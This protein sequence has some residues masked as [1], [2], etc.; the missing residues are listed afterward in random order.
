VPLTL[1]QRKSSTSAAGTGGSFQASWQSQPTQGNLLV[2]VANSDSALTMVSTGWTLAISSVNYVALYQFYK[3]AGA[4]ESSVVDITVNSGNFSCGVELEEYAGNAPSTPLDQTASFSPTTDGDATISTGTTPTTTQAD[5][6]ALVAFGMLY[7]TTSITAITNSFVEV[8][9]N[10]R[11]ISNPTNG[12]DTALTVAS[13]ALTAT[14]TQNAVGTLDTPNLRPSGI[15]GTYKAGSVFPT[16]A[17]TSGLNNTAL[18]T[19]HVVPLPAPAGG[20]LKDDIV[21]IFGGLG[22]TGNITTPAGWNDLL[23][24]TGTSTGTV[25]SGKAQVLWKRM[26]GGETGNV[27][28]TTASSAGGWTSYCI[29]GAHKAVDPVASSVVNGAATANIANPPA[30]NPATWGVEDTLWIAA[31]TV[32]GNLTATAAPTNYTDLIVNNWA[33]ASGAALATARRNNAVASEDPG[34]FTHGAGQHG[35]WVVAIRPAGIPQF[36]RR[37]PVR[38]LQAVNRSS[39]W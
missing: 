18:T 35:A 14:G 5:E 2:A 21:L 36:F 8:V 17:A 20:I 31:M 38:K 9:D 39:I 32:D 37:E 28:I 1:V 4:S 25:A 13:K 33:N 12:I 24:S 30:L 6:L 16:V 15:I 34:V 11:A 29:R 23:T 27:T 19:S 7:P 22:T 10:L 26:A 3:I